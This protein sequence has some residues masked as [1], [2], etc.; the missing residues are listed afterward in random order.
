MRKV[1][2]TGHTSGL[3][4]A[5]LERFSV[6]DAVVGLSRSNGFDIRKIQPILD[7]VEDCDVFI[8]N[9]YDRYSQVD[10]L[11][12]VYAMWKGQD[13]KIVNISS[14]ASV[15]IRDEI[16]FYSIHKK[17]LNEAHYQ[18]VAQ[19]NTCKS[20]NIVSGYI[21]SDRREPLSNLIYNTICDE[22]YIPEI[23]VFP[24]DR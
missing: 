17:A 22:I 19:F 13:K 24:N 6:S 8:N 10:L 20:Y 12:S 7:R 4:A 23:A 1:A 9:A 2:I 21:D 3:G 14:M 16:K 5:L 11:Y 18:V 15:G